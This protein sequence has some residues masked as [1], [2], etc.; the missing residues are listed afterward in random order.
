[1]RPATED[2]MARILQA[3]A[4]AIGTSP[5]AVRPAVEAA[6]REARATAASVHAV[7]LAFTPGAV[8]PTTE[9]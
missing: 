1:M 9:T 6:F 2:V 5:A 7:V 4:T 8:S 3:A